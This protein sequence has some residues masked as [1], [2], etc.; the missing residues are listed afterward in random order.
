MVKKRFYSLI[1]VLGLSIGITAC[2]LIGLFVSSELSY[3]KFN[4]KASRIVRLTMEYSSSGTVNK[5][6]MTG[7]KAGPQLMRTFPE[8]GLYQARE[9]STIYLKWNKSLR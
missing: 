7:N 6:P 9:I 2:L 8:G 5:V 4:E 3:D 1:N